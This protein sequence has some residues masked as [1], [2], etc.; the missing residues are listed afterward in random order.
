MF[1]NNSYAIPVLTPKTPCDINDIE[2][3]NNYKKYNIPIIICTIID[4]ICINAILFD[5]IKSNT[6]LA[7][8]I[9]TWFLFGLVIKLIFTKNHS[10][11]IKALIILL[12]IIFISIFVLKINL[13]K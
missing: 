6:A 13:K 10:M 7:C 8:I 1:S 5:L 11:K 12:H 9:F 2:I 4:V 3:E